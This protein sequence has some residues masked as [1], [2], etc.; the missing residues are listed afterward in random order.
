MKEF[1]DKVAVITGAGSGIGYAFAVRCV[2]EG[3][4]VALADIN[5]RRLKTAGRRL[6]KLGATEILSVKTDVS[7]PDEVK[8]LAKLTFDKFGAVHLLFNNAGVT[9]P[10]YTWNYT[11]KDWE[12]QLGVNLF[13]VI[14][15]IN[16]FAPTMLK[17]E[18]E[19]IIIN[20]ASVEGLIHGSGAGGAIY[21]ASKHAIVSMSET[22]KMEL[23]GLEPQPKLKVI[24]LC[25]GF[26]NTKIFHFNANRP[27]ELIN[28][29]E[30]ELEDT[31]LDASLDTF[32]NNLEEGGQNPLSAE[33]CVNIAFNGI[34]ND[35]FYILTHNNKSFKDNLKDR[36][37]GILK[38]FDILDK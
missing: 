25:P 13:G 37:D 7:N 28:A 5:E 17:Q 12:W 8:N 33:E 21:G 16:N 2:K 20:N 32:R 29:P 1:Q 27:E 26:I 38:S 11:V 14:Y 31:K 36:R 9:N 24:A 34:R 22:L 35:E 6:K 23:E 19:S 30:E 10:K 3:M 15:G 18:F 4:K